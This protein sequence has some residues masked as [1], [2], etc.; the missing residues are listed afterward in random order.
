M[1][2]VRI[3]TLGDEAVEEQEKLDAK[4]RSEA[5]KAEKA[6]ASAEETSTQAPQ[7][8]EKTEPKKKATSSTS[9][10]VRSEKYLAKAAKRDKSHEYKLSEAVEI[11]PS[12]GLGSF[13]ETVELHINTNTS[14]LSGTLSLP[15]GTGKQTRVAIATEELISEIEKG[16]ISFDVLIAE[17]M[18][19]AKLAKVAKILG[20]RG[21]MPNP[22]NGTVSPK[23]EEVAKKFEGGQTNYKTEAKFPILHVSVGKVSFGPEKIQAN[24]KNAI[25]TIQKANIKNVT[26]KSTMSPALK[27]DLASL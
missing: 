12:L 1:G 24:I 27:L 5:K 18:M 11:L 14:G 21:L 8:E 19:M 2:K 4:K 15:H 7:K 9:K 16:T 13:D 10:K 17:P 22:K 20:P 26:L 23:P 6:G 25:Q 3:K